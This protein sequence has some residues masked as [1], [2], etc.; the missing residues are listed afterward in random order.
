MHKRSIAC[1]LSSLGADTS[2]TVLMMAVVVLPIM[3]GFVGLATDTVQWMLW[4]RQFQQVADS[5]AISA[6]YAMS[7]GDDPT[8]AANESIELD[9]HIVFLHPPKITTQT[10]TAEPQATVQ[11]SG[12]R[13]LPFSKM[14]MSEAPILQA[15]A[16][17]SLLNNG[18]FCVV[19][20][21]KSLTGISVNG[22]A[23]VD[24]GCGVSSNSRSSQ[25]ITAGG[26]SLLTATPLS[27][28]GGIPKS[29]NIAS[30]RILPY[31]LA[32][33]DPFASLKDPVVPSSC[34][35]SGNVSPKQSQTIVITPGCYKRGI[36][37]SGQGTVRMSPGVYILDGGNFSTGSQVTVIGEG[38]TIVLTSSTVTTS[39][40]SVGDI[41][42]SAGSNIRLIA[43]TTSATG[44]ASAY[45]GTL[46]YQ[47]RRAST[48]G[49][50]KINGNANLFLQGGIYVPKRTIEM[51]GGGS[52]GTSCLQ[53]VA[54]AVAFTGN[55]SV[56][57]TCPTDAG[58]KEIVGAVVRLIQ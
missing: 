37:L 9:D 54:R 11:L 4:Q 52:F 8:A 48:S 27:S 53:L 19:S 1:R 41:D 10:E 40:A 20:L 21:E 23:R 29:A 33:A 25:S 39:P 6:V 57:N 58:V 12:R 24:L 16:T 26:S 36:S 17:A 2:G 51:N 3:L 28:V 47:D 38:V 55:S 43:P 31:S 45:K 56:S 18:T 50:S 5:G 15:T 22:S 34:N 14:F 35:L 44:D 13:A 46:F 42:I 49:T 30:E 32:R 7:A